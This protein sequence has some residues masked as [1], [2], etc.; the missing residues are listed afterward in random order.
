[1]KQNVIKN[2]RGEIVKYNHS[3]WLGISGVYGGSGGTWTV[4]DG[5]ANWSDFAYRCDEQM[6]Q[7]FGFN[8]TA[9]FFRNFDKTWGQGTSR[10]PR[11]GRM[12]ADTR[13]LEPGVQ[14]EV[15]EEFEQEA[16]EDVPVQP[17]FGKGIY[18]YMREGG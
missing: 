7:F 4:L 14:E 16:L 17:T 1:M 11:F 5:S 3:K 12:T 15:Q 9:A 10:P 6:Q 8:R 18:K 2:R 13:A